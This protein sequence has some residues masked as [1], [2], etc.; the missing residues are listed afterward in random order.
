MGRLP[1]LP[2]QAKKPGAVSE[3]PTDPDAPPCTLDEVKTC[4]R[5]GLILVWTEAYGRPPPK[6]LSR[7]LLEYAAAYHIQAKEFGG[8]SP[9]T[10][11]KLYRLADAAKEGRA[12]K[13]LKPKLGTGSRLF[14]EWGGRTH[15]VEVMG[16]GFRYDG[17]TYRSLSEIARKITGTRWSGPRFFGTSPRNSVAPSIPASR[18]TRGSSRISIRWMPS[19][20]PAKP[21]SSASA[22][23]VGGPSQTSS[24][25][26]G[27][28]ADRWI[29]LLSPGYW[30]W[31]RAAGS[32]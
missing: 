10:K 25:T 2:C 22:M 15:A 30:T 5:A 17:A 28:R 24:M 21:T 29:A 31:S 6:G 19:E 13:A 9:A 18:P 3:P 32:T 1:R 23:R 8:L 26:V 14:R 16:S 4:S 12:A 27:T 20:R 7:R 11:R